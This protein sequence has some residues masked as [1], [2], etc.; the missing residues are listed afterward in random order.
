MA[1]IIVRTS[2][3]ALRDFENKLSTIRADLLQDAESLDR[4]YQNAQWNDM[5]SEK[6]RL[7]VNAYLDR[8]ND[9]LAGLNGVIQAV[10]K[11]QELAD[12]YE[13]ME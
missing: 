10:W 1:E 11:L 8:F 2:A 13:S 4:A 6:A 3:S 5:V 12:N 9:A 7:E